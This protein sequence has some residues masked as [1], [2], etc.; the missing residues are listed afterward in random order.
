MHNSLPGLMGLRLALRP[1]QEPYARISY[2]GNNDGISAAMA[3]QKHIFKPVSRNSAQKIV[4]VGGCQG[5]F[6]KYKFILKSS[7]RSLPHW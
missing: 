3:Q 7:K 1:T 6:E 4:V 5:H 2:D